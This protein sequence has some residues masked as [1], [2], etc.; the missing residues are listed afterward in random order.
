MIR[1]IGFIGLLLCVLGGYFFIPFIFG[2]ILVWFRINTYEFLVIGILSDIMMRD[3][4]SLFIFP[5]YFILA[6][7][8]VTIIPII[9]KYIFS[10]NNFGTLE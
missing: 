4:A 9:Q 2:I 6:L 8:V 7:V 3:N 10:S 1:F 5:I